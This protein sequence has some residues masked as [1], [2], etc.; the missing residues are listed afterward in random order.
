MIKI[1]VGINY[2]DDAEGLMR[3][4]QSLPKCITRIYIIDGAYPGR[5]DKA[6]YK[7]EMTMAIVHAMRNITY[8]K[9]NNAKQIDKRN[10][11]WELAE[12]DDMDWLIVMDSDEYLEVEDQDMFCAYL[13][14]MSEQFPKPRCFPLAGN[15][16]G[17][18][19]AVP[20][21][22]K[23]PFNYRHIQQ[24]GKISH[25]SIYD[26][27]GKEIIDE[28]YRYY[29][30]MRDKLCLSGEKACVP[31]LRLVHDKTYRDKKRIDADYLWYSDNPTR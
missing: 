19:Q 12:K 20:R 28:M 15:N 31:F 24:E 22:F 29:E 4:L 27:E 9:M 6:E 13:L 23:G 21:L 30:Y 10:K 1:A 25:G 5:Y 11:Y 17:N 14:K 26:P 16:M 2:W 8:I 7:D 18:F 3:L